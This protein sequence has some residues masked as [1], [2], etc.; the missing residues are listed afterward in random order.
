MLT[1]KA[2]L[3]PYSMPTPMTPTDAIVSSTTE[4]SYDEHVPCK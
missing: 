4:S 1:S 3:V 2:A